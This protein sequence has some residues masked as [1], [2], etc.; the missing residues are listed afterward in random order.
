MTN[1]S[2]D[3]K[4]ITTLTAVPSCSAILPYFLRPSLVN[5][6]Y[7]YGDNYNG[8]REDR[9]RKEEQRSRDEVVEI[10]G[11]LL[12]PLSSNIG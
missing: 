2:R 5:T 4:E 12:P 3:L 9:E 10:N 7:L 11:L 6:N 8:G 1:S